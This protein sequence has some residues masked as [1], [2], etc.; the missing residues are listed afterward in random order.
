MTMQS[1]NRHGL[2]ADEARQL[3]EVRGAVAAGE[4]EDR[5]AESLEIVH[6]GEDFLG[7]EFAGKVDIGGQ[8]I[9]VQAVEVGAIS[10]SATP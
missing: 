10:T 8:R 7:R 1:T 3:T 2:S 4:D 5:H 9:A 6:D